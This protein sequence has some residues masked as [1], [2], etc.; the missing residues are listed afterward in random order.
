MVAVEKGCVIFIRNDDDGEKDKN[1][2]TFYRDHALLPFVS[3]LRHVYNRWR[4]L[5]LITEEIKRVSW[6]DGNH[7]QIKSI[8]NTV[9]QYETHHISTFKHNATRTGIEQGANL[10]SAFHSMQTLHKNTPS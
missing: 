9:N 4:T 1:C 3:Q 5:M 8:I 7:T 2:I 10:T 6:C